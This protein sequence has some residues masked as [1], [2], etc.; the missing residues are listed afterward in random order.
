[1]KFINLGIAQG[2]FEIIDYRC[3]FSTKRFI[4]GADPGG[5]DVGMHP[6]LSHFQQCFG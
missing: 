6:A 4:A 5:G 3:R 1:M 2:F